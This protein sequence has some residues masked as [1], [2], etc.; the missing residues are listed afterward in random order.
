MVLLAGRQTGSETLRRDAS[1]PGHVVGVLSGSRQES[2]AFV[3]ATLVEEDESDATTARLASA[4]LVRTPQEWVRLVDS[5][6]GGILVP[7]FP[8]ADLTAATGHGLTVVVPLGPGSDSRRATVELPRINVAQ[9]ID[10]LVEAKV[11][12]EDAERIAQE[13]DRSLPSF[14]RSNGTNPDYPAPSWVSTS[15]DLIAPL[16]LLGGWEAESTPDQEVV[17]AVANR[18]YADVESS[19]RVLALWEDP[20]FFES[21]TGWQVSSAQDAFALVGRSLTAGTLD[22][23]RTAAAKLLPEHDADDR[24]PSREEIEAA[25]RGMRLKRSAAIRDGVARGAVLLGTFGERSQARHANLLVRELLGGLSGPETW[26][27]LSPVLP[28]LAEAAPDQFLE[29]AE[30][31]VRAGFL[32]AMFTDAGPAPLLG[33]RSPHTELLWSLELL[34]RSPAHAARACEVLAA[35]DEI[36]PGGRGSN[37]PFDSLRRVLLPWHPQIAATAE[38]RLRI[39]EG[40]LGRHPDVGWKLLTSLLPGQWDST[41]P[42]YAP[43]FRPWRISPEI[44]VAERFA[45]WKSVTRLTIERRR[46]RRPGAAARD[47]RDDSDPPARRPHLLDR[48]TRRG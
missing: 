33:G 8:E 47:R 4:L 32:V 46:R 36:D 18:G 28:A 2:L 6:P 26:V 25:A 22:R 15:A 35:L 45:S 1:K 9:A 27:A 3:A 19:L 12:R 41:H 39:I 43:V 31:S 44:S 38:E 21:G 7:D 10:R 23:W 20:P 11:R 34:S 37:R 24:M 42:T 5:M 29:A 13:V 16:V 30:D 17:A 48:R 40:I 14:R